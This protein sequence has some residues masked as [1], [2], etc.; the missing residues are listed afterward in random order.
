MITRHQRTKEEKKRGY[1]RKLIARTCLERFR[2]PTSNYKLSEVS[3]AL[4]Q[5][6]YISEA[7]LKDPDCKISFFECLF[8]YNRIVRCARTR[9]MIKCE[10]EQ[11]DGNYASIDYVTTRLRSF[12]DKTLS[13][14]ANNIEQ[15]TR[16]KTHEY[17][18]ELARLL[19]SP[20]D[21]VQH[22]ENDMCVIMMRDI[23][24]ELT[25]F[26]KFYLSKKLVEYLGYSEE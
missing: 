2:N 16:N 8:E 13:D 17:P 1:L 25:T 4:I 12:G 26:N 15:A 21:I 19:P 7:I 11:F 22:Y 14:V 5:S 20:E 9:S 10:L 18:P 24:P 23:V 3:P 6:V